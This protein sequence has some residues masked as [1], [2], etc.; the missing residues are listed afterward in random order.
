VATALDRWP[1]LDGYA[2]AHN[3]PYL[4]ELPVDRFANFV[5]WYFTRER[6]KEDVA[7]FDALL[8][9]PEKGQVVVDDRS[10]WS[11]ENEKKGFSAFARQIGG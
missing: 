9:M 8:W 5:Y 4:Q 7:K 6:D 1:E 11:A 3:M 10:P 2:V